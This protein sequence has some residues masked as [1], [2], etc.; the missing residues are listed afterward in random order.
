M[1]AT[2]ASGGSAWLWAAGQST[3]A[4]APAGPPPANVRVGVV[5]RQQVQQRRTV[6]GRIDP[7]WRSVVASEEP[8]RVVQGP[9]E[10]GTEVKAGQTLAKL[11]TTLLEID[12]SAAAATLAEAEQIVTERKALL[13]SAERDRVRT[14]ELVLSDAA[15]EK[16]LADKTD[17]AHAAR[18]RHAA[19]Q[20]LL[21]RAKLAVERLDA[22]LA[23]TIIVAPFDAVTVTKQTE[24][25]Q[26]LEPGA[27]VCEVVAIDSVKALLFVPES[28]IGQVRTDMPVEVSVDAYGERRTGPVWRIVPDADPQ[29]RTFRVFVKL[30]NDPS[31]GRLLMPGMSVSSELTTGAV[32]EAITVPRDAVHSTPTGTV[33]FVNRG[34]AA[35]PVPVIVRFGAGDRFVVD[36]AL[37]PDEQVVVEG[38]ERLI[39][40]QRLVVM[41]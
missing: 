19:A 41:P 30:D 10:S 28:M 11:D 34:G 24:Q 32:T 29:S 25:G 31:L 35:A 13:D 6:V 5:M 18:A 22:R 39:P 16:E 40:G 4:Q 21:E 15:K 9:P 23:K 33:V 1:L 7:R 12:R 27:P 38:N 26:W 8:G 14:A 17:T 36:G 20:V 2:V 3:P 37:Q